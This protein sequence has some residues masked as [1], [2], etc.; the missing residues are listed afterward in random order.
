MNLLYLLF[1]KSSEIP[2]SVCT[3]TNIH[4]PVYINTYTHPFISLYFQLNFLA[5]S[6]G[7]MWV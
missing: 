3:N 2:V 1:N 5:K 4:I 7:S 6:N